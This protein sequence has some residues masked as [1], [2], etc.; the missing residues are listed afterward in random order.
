MAGDYRESL[1][2]INSKTGGRNWVYASLVKGKFFYQRAVVAY[3]LLAIYLLA[4]WI[5][6]NGKQAVHLDIFN[7]QFTFLGV[8]FWATDTDF[9][10]N[11]FLIAG[12]SLFFFTAVLGRVWCGWACPETVFL[13]F[14]FRPIERLIEGDAAKR[15][16]LD[17]APWTLNKII[18]KSLKHGFC[19]IMA[20]IIASTALAYFVG[21]E[22]L[23]NMMLQ[24]PAANP[25]LFTA[26]LIY[27]GLMAF[28]FGWFREQFCT[29]LCPYARFQS[30]LMDRF[31]LGVGYDVLRG[32]PRGKAS[33]KQELNLGDCVD[34]GLCVRV[35]PTGIDIRNGVQLECIHCASCVDACDSVMSKL[36]RPTGLIRYGCEETL[37][38]GGKFK[39][40][41]RPF[42]YSAVL[43]VLLSVFVYR[44]STRQTSEVTI[45]RGA[46]DA[47]FVQI[48]ANNISNHVHV[49]LSNKSE[50]E[51]KFEF[52][53]DDPAVKLVTPLH[54]FPVA[55]ESMATAPL[56][57]NFPTSLLKNGKY[58][59][60][61]KISSAS[62]FSAEQEITLLGP[63]K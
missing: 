14:V 10:V 2:T 6:I 24:S 3:L 57:I 31:S 30:V 61:I 40:S 56:F 18:K 60:K 37:I 39:L 23:I 17:Q 9:L 22:S 19:A 41:P 25:G 54:P 63:G 50:N 53:S 46:A 55:A 27:M 5:V 28:Q 35:C 8:T 36:G 52:I 16:R 34:C 62:G 11:L 51:E 7:R 15:I 21:R 45:L 59:L 49:K 42:I 33:K 26:T 13:E 1:Y 12:L 32:E 20:W 43:V 44:L 4:P 47:P 29:V 48:D 38:R 58:P